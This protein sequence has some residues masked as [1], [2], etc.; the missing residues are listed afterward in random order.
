MKRAFTLST[1]AFAPAGRLPDEQV[2]NGM[3][4]SGG[5]M[6]P[7]LAW[8]GAPQGTRSF[9][10]MMHDPDAPTGS[11]WWHWVVYNIPAEVQGLKAGAGAVD[12]S[13][14][15]A[16]A[17][18]GTNDYGTPGYGGACPPKGDKPHRYDFR[19]F[20]LKVE[21]IDPPPGAT[22]AMIGFMVHA[23]ALGVASIHATYG[24]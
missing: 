21:K 19:L 11:G 10:L 16:G 14:L 6:S 20:A 24:R 12:G 18:H 9:A 2:F 23:N 15:P 17:M 4:C 22:A 3:G 1:P 8:S 13:K 7:E 5:N